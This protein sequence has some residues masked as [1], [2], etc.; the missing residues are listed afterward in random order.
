MPGIFLENVRK[1]SPLIHNIT[2]YVT[3]NDVANIILACGGSP[4]MADE[5]SEVEEITSICNAL[6]INIGTLNERTIKSMFLAGERARQLGHPIVL[7][8]V[9]VGASKIRSETALSLTEK[10]KP[11]VIRG[12]VSEIKALFLGNG[13][14]RGVDA[15]ISDFVTEENLPQMV[16]FAKKFSSKTGAVIA[17]TGKIDL[18]ADDKKCFVIRNGCGE[19]SRI[20]GTGCQLSGM[21]AAFVAVNSSEKTEAVA[22][23]VCAM[24]LAG[25]IA[26]S[27]MKAGDGNSS[28]RNG[29]I[30]A[31]YNM[32]GDILCKG[33][34]YVVE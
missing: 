16:D 9:G 4:I 12:N 22:A 13:S 18:V 25:E 6:N 27:K 29:I 5:I 21:I 20:T 14:T 7:D 15:S 26:F 3:V 33:A 1:G 32:N 8:P 10:V 17:V 24:G 30:D 2:N 19:M 34:K 28:L 31:V 23:A 11:D